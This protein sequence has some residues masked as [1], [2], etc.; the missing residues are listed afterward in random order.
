MKKRSKWQRAWLW[1]RFWTRQFWCRVR[2]VYPIVGD[3]REL[4]LVRPTPADFSFRPRVIPNLMVES[5]D[6]GVHKDGLVVIRQDGSRVTCRLLP[7]HEDMTDDQILSLIAWHRHD[8]VT[9]EELACFA[10]Q[11]RNHLPYGCRVMAVRSTVQS[12][13]N[14]VCAY[15]R[16]TPNRELSYGEKDLT[17]EVVNRHYLFKRIRPAGD[18]VLMRVRD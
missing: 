15:W 14:W 7:L 2:G 12:G 13:D 8:E 5:S 6:L 17:G 18:Y 11:Y 3:N 1:L 16:G 10:E 4:E 9:D